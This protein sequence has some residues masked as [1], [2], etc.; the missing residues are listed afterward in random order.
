MVAVPNE[1][2]VFEVDSK[3]VDVEDLW[4]LFSVDV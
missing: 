4:S 1:T 2:V 3:I